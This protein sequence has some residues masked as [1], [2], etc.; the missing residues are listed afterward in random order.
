MREMAGGAEAPA[1]WIA[2]ALE[3]LRR[4]GAE[5]YLPT[6]TERTRL[7]TLAVLVAVVAGWLLAGI[8][9]AVAL[10]ALAPSFAGAMVAHRR[11]R[12]R[13]AVE[14]AVPDIAR[15]IADCLSAGHSPRGALVAASHSLEGPAAA[16]FER[17]RADLELGLSTRVAVDALSER[18]ASER[19][20]AFAMAVTSQRS[21]GGDLAALLRRF[22]EGAAERDRVAEDARSATAQARFTGYLVVAMPAGAALFTELLRPGFLSSLASSGPALAVLGLSVLM[23]GG[24][25]IAISRLARVGEA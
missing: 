22:A 21:A 16:E 9:V 23:Q 20:D 10:A 5:G 25:F 17:F 18:F 6:S 2:A 7:A 1:A 24:G 11:R 12:Y 14:R 19:I 3:P 8:V 15:A 4:A 13:R